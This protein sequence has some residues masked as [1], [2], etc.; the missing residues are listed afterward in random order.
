MKNVKAI[1]GILLVFTL[2]AASGA[3][4]MHMIDRAHHESF[5]KGGAEA[6]EDVIISRLTQKLDLDAQQQEQVRAIIHENHAA[7]SQIRNQLHP[8]IQAIIEEGQKRINAALRPDQQE[9]F[10]QIIE[11]RKKR[12][13]Q[14]G[15]STRETH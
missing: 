5:V 10:R 1:I 11:D 15:P 14:E 2:G 6:R 7:I 4:V 8:Q 13:T 9:K 3:V 12:Y